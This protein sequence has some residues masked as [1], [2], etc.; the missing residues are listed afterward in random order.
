PYAPLC[1]GALFLRNS[2]A[3]HR[4]SLERVTDFLRD[5]VWGGDRVVEFVKKELYRDRF[6]ERGTSVEATPAPGSSMAAMGPLPAAVEADTSA[7][8]LT[9][10]HLSIDLDAPNQQAWPGRWYPVSDLQG[11][12]ASIISPQNISKAILQN[13]E[14][15]VSALSPPE[16]SA[17]AYLVS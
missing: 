4:T 6:L 1:A 15:S 5:R 10:D 9:N 14:R 3:G 11:V 2:V 17:L 8:S 12:M 7:L 13:H 16:L